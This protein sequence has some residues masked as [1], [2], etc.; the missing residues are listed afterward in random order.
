MKSQEKRYVRKNIHSKEAQN[1]VQALNKALK[2][3]REKD[4]SDP[5]SWYYQG[6]IHWVPDTISNNVLCESYSNVSQLKDGWDNCTHSPSGQEEL[7][8]LLWHRLYI[9]HFEK[10][11]RKLSGYDDFALPYWAY[12]NNDIENKRLQ[13]LF[14]D[15]SSSLFE[16][17]RY[18]SLNMGYP[19]SGEIARS[20]D[21]TK[22]LKYES[23]EMFCK[24]IDAA[25]HGAMHDYIGAGNDTSTVPRF[26]NKITRGLTSTGL[27][28][29]VPTAAFDPVFWTHHSNIDRI[30]QQWSN[31][32]NGKAVTM[33]ILKDAPWSYVFFDENGKKVEYTV[34]QALDLAYSLDYDFDD[35]KVRKPENASSQKVKSS[36]LLSFAPK[37][38]LKGHHSKIFVGSKKVNKG[39]TVTINVSFSKAPRGSYE[40][41]LNNTKEHPHPSD[42]S[43]LGFM[44]FFGSDHKM[45][46][47]TCEKGCCTKLN[48]DGRNNK[49]FKFQVTSH[50]SSEDLTIDVIKFNKK[51]HSDFVIEKIE[52]N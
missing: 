4:C 28:G 49:T 32:P 48:G 13:E 34:E 47:E 21:L 31:S 42:E 3:M 5:L 51:V 25:P 18:D 33:E 20:L 17:A 26:Q 35:T 46:G 29:W 27:M 6:A 1:D 12:T 30:W 44:T 39:N 2:I 7:H 19:V 41:Y 45:A 40:V 11:V 10:I 43:F 15:P 37:A 9:H 8:F 14:R 50:I 38:K 36:K 22:L 23:Y 16:V 24:N 52:I